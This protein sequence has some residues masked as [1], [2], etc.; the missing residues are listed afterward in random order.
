ML[1]R[2]PGA[3][4]SLPAQPPSVFYDRGRKEEHFFLIPKLLVLHIIKA[5]EGFFKKASESGISSAHL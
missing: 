2:E 3:P 5:A 1:P 4:A